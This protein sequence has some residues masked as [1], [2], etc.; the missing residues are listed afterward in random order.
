MKIRV[1]F[2][3]NH[4]LLVEKPINIPVQ[5]DSSG[6]LDLLTML[7]DDLKRRYQKPGNV[8]L[9]LVHRLDRPVG[10]VMVFAKTSKAA[11]RLSDMIRR[12]IIERHYL[13]VVH[14]TPNRKRGQ[15]VH[16]LH[17]GNRKNK[18]AVVDPNHP[19][20]KKAVLDFEVIESKKGLS[21]LSVYLYTGR[22]HQIRVQLSTIGNPIFGDQK[23]GEELAKSGQQ[24]A[25]WAH[26]IH[27]EHPVRKEP[28]GIQ[29]VPPN[30]EPWNIWELVR[31]LEKEEDQRLVKV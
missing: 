24:I 22:P 3:D 2:E 23:Y 15:L 6:N 7:K 12:N 19:D 10:G 26:S 21:L 31:N 14:G 9:G 11:S 5:E 8:Y 16:Y 18:V 29:S 13:A 17:K 25:L 28:I 4:L 27:F 20:A 30:K 1:L